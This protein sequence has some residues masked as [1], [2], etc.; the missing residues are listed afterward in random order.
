MAAANGNGGWKKWAMGV[1][2]GITL[3]CAT[4][5][6]LRGRAEAATNARQ[7]SEILECRKEN[8]RQDEEIKM[9]RIANE[10]MREKLDD[11]LA[12]S[13]QILTEIRK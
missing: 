11:I 7:D 2:A 13:T 9:L 4:D 1:M 6:V 5:W 3:F 10:K 8:E 12:M